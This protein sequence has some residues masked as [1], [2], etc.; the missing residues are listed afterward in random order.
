MEC[1]Y[2]KS[3]DMHGPCHDFYGI[4]CVEC[5][6][7]VMIDRAKPL[8]RDLIAGVIVDCIYDGDSSYTDVATDC[9]DRIIA[10]LA[11]GE[12]A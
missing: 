1:P 7:T 12:A 9:A 5:G 8:D 10:T 6:A 3:K 11:S 2:C 4:V